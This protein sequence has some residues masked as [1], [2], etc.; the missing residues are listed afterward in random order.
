MI[1]KLVKKRKIFNNQVKL[2]YRHKQ[3]INLDKAYRRL[4][5]L[6]VKI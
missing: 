2:M 3:K 5:R 6:Q 1:L 4:V